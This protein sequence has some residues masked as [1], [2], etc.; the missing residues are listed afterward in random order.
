MQ[1]SPK[2]GSFSRLAL[3]PPRLV[4]EEIKNGI[5]R[6]VFEECVYK[7]SGLYRF[8]FGQ[9]VEHRKNT[10]ADRLTALSPGFDC[11]YQWMYLATCLP[12]QMN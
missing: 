8:S 1:K 5:W 6:Y 4:F 11:V 7:I 10:L 3:N 9:E 12:L 2:N